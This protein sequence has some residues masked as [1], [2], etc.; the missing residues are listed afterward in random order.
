MTTSNGIN[1]G[2]NAGRICWLIV[3]TMCKGDAENNFEGMFKTCSTCDFYHLV[4]EEE[5]NTLM[6]SLEVLRETYEKVKA[7]KSEEQS[8]KR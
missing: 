8:K 2:R 6:F 1:S 7:K 4:R 3:N 5:G